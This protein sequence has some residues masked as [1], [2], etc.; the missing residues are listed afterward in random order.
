MVKAECKSKH[1]WFQFNFAIQKAKR[2]FL[3]MKKGETKRETS[4][5]FNKS[6]FLGR[7]VESYSQKLH[8]CVKSPNHFYHT[9]GGKLK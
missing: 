9:N 8:P 2:N 5:N 1:C 3:F 6:K 7:K 4:E